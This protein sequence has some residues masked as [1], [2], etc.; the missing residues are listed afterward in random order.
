MGRALRSVAGAPPC[1]LSP[2][3]GWAVVSGCWAVLGARDPAGQR[4]GMGGR[5]GQHSKGLFKRPVLPAR[6]TLWSSPGAAA[7]FPADPQVTWLG[8]GWLCGGRGWRRPWGTGQSWVRSGLLSPCRGQGR[9]LQ[10]WAVGLRITPSYFPG[11]LKPPGGVI[12]GAEQGEPGADSCLNKHLRP[13]PVM[14]P[15]GLVIGVHSQRE[16]KNVNIFYNP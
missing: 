10:S 15:D 11:G 8:L 1:M 13:A 3:G 14:A 16:L 7:A 9:D 5:G 2:P 6:R 4:W 12:L